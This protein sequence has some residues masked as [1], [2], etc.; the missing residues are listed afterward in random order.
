MS[1]LYVWSRLKCTQTTLEQW[2][3]ENQIYYFGFFLSTNYQLVHILVENICNPTDKEKT[4]SFSW[5]R[6]QHKQRSY[7]SYDFLDQIS[8]RLWHKLVCA[9]SFINPAHTNL[10]QWRIKESKTR[11]CCWCRGTDQY[12]CS[13]L[14]FDHFPSFLTCDLFILPFSF[15]SLLKTSFSLLKTSFELSYF[16]TGL[17]DYRI[18]F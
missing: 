14:S 5:L 9:R 13:I 7:V 15:S 12:Y 3:S 17:N 1:K 2:Y 18:G 11:K 10:C 16:T 8:V 6:D 4:Q